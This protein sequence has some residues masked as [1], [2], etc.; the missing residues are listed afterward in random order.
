MLRLPLKNSLLLLAFI[1]SSSGSLSSAQSLRQPEPADI[2]DPNIGVLGTGDGSA[3]IGPTLPHGS[4]HPSPDT[5]AGGQAGYRSDKPIRGFSQLHASGTGWGEYGNL[6]L[7]PQIGLS[8]VPDG[9]DSPKADERAESY[10]YRVR[11]S[12]YNIVTELSPTQHAAMYRLTYPNS[13][14]AHLM[15]DLGQQIPGQLGTKPGDGKVVDSEI[16]INPKDGSFRGSSRYAGGFGGGEYTVYFYGEI[17][18][19]AVSFGTWKN[20]A[21]QLGST[22]ERWMKDGDRVGAW[23]RFSAKSSA[24]VLLKIGVSLRSIDRARDYVTSE[25]P[26]WDYE[27][28]RASARQA[29]NQALGSIAIAGGDATQRTLFYTALYHA[30]LMPRDRTGDMERFA[31]NQP[32]WDDFYATWDIWRTKFPLMLWIDPAM[33]RGSISSFNAR[34]RVDGQVRDAFVAGYGGRG[35]EA[36]RTTFAGNRG[37]QPDQGGNDADNIIADAYVKGLRGVDWEKAY[38]VLRFDAD[39]ERQG[40]FVE[41]AED[42]RRQGWIRSGIMSVSNTL[43]YAYNDYAIAQVASGLGKQDD[44]KRYLARASQWQNLFNPAV[45]SDGYKGFS[46]PR[47]LNGSWVA[48][49]PKQYPGSW[50]NYFYEANSW[51]Y[52]LFAPHQ[53]NRLL[54]LMGGPEMFAKRLDHANSVPLIDFFNEP[55]FL[56]PT[57]FHYA[58]RPDLSAKWM[59]RFI[60]NRYTLR[61]YPGDDDS[62][63]MSSYYV[64]VSMGIFPN[65]GQDIYFLSGPL[66]DK[67]TVNRPEDGLLIIT[68]TGKGEYIGA[69]T[70]NGKPLDRAWVH[71]REISG[72]TLLAFTMSV[73]P[74][75]W[76]KKLPPPSDEGRAK[77][78]P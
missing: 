23:W 48:F 59:H 43:E 2:V 49:D 53:V 19:H 77:P 3:V 13:D 50:K 12:R 37:T 31:I 17:K 73:E 45:E 30:Q 57:L 28:V 36:A 68:R 35:R 38:E 16:R 22:S 11:L 1:V 33:V 32:M 29:W 25:V 14:Q 46:M 78:L 75:D 5:A 66:Y 27:Q 6:L 62:G 74:T 56:A 26:A 42:Y 20:A 61:G 71:Q 44:A 39:Q 9:H 65:A 70:I 51:T 10:A 18:Q 60:A 67:I 54:E 4:V 69:A 41:G 8:V 63:A 15:L 21:V 7:S 72:D 40:N 34:L 55:G 58:G 64:W 47:N 52:S 76:G 24:P